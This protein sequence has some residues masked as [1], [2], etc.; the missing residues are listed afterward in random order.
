MHT[1]FIRTAF[2][3]FVIIVVMRLMGKRQIGQLQP[4]ELVVTILL[5]EV[6]AAPMVDRDIPLLYSLSSL[7]LLTGVELLLSFLALKNARIRTILQGNSVVLIRNGVINLEQCK[8]L[9]YTLDDILEA[10]RQKDVFDISEV[11]F[12]VAETNGSLSVYLKP[13]YRNPT[14]G[15]LDC[16]PRDSGI[17]CTLIADGELL[18][19]GLQESS[20]SQQQINKYLKSKKKSINDVLLLTVDGDGNFVL[21]GK[22]GR[23]C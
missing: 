19:E 23:L 6:A 15:D 3:F 14:N 22:D 7:M 1:I 18:Q 12:A 20:V 5:S 10:L 21:F 11:E 8:K 17:P 13:Q 16:T 9:R 4:A 2:L